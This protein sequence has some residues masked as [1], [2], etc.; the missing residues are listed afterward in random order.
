MTKEIAALERLK[1]CCLHVFSIDIDPILFKL[2]GN[3]GMHNNNNNK[4]IIMGELEFRQDRTND[5]GVSYHCAPNIYPIDCHNLT[6]KLLRQGFHNFRK[7]FSKC[8]SEKNQ[9]HGIFNPEFYGD[10]VYKVKK[11]IGNPNFSFFFK[12]IANRLKKVGYNLDIMRQTACLVF[13]PIMVEG[14]AALN[15]FTV[16]VQAPDSMM[17]L[18]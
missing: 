13:N 3:E 14:Y 11:I 12:R 10:L 15:S 16:V 2:A 9:Q 17:A 18:T 5:Y 8:Q 4:L 1:Y 6:A 7:A